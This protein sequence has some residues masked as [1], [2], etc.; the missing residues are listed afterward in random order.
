MDATLLPLGMDTVEQQVN[1][2]ELA[3]GL[4]DVVPTKGEK[5]AISLLVGFVEVGYAEA[6]G[7]QIIVLIYHKTS[8]IEVNKGEVLFDVDIDFLLGEGDE[9]IEVLESGID[10]IEEFACVGIDLLAGFEFEES[11]VI[12]LHDELVDAGH[13]VGDGLRSINLILSP[14]AGNFVAS[15]FNEIYVILGVVEGADVLALVETFNHPAF[16]IHVGKAERTFYLGH[17]LLF[18]P[19]HDGVEELGEDIV[20]LN[21]VKPSETDCLFVPP[22]IDRVVYDS[23]H[24]AHNLLAA[25]GEPGFEVAM[26]QRG[27]LLGEQTQFVAHQRRNVSR[28][29]LEEPIGELDKSAYIGTALNFFN[30]NRFHRE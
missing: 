17:S 5:M 23:S 21:E 20:I 24:A 16:F 13:L 18:T 30:N 19:S 29:I 6:E 2:L 7:Y 10:G 15:T 12:L 28:H 11:Q 8:E 3:Q 9:I 1:V 4:Q 14:L 22:L 26:I 27:V 25:I